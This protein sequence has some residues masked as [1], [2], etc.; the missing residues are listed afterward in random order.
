MVGQGLGRWLGGGDDEEVGGRI[1]FLIEG[2]AG[3]LSGV[4]GVSDNF[5]NLADDQIFGNLLS[6]KAKDGCFG[7]KG[8]IGWQV[9]DIGL[10][11]FVDVVAF[12][13]GL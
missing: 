2:E 10:A 7:V 9:D 6:G 4:G 5:F 1:N 12:G 13:P 8:G 11:A 3:F